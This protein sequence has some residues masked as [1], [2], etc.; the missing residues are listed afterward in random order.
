M[1]CVSCEVRT[2]FVYITELWILPT[3]CIC[4]LRMVHTINNECSPNSINLSVLVAEMYCVSCEVR[5]EFLCIVYK[6]FKMTCESTWIALRKSVNTPIQ[7]SDRVC[8]RKSQLERRV[9]M[10]G[11]VCNNMFVY[12]N[13]SHSCYLRRVDTAGS[14]RVATPIHMRTRAVWHMNDACN[15][16]TVEVW[17]I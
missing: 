5:T 3:Q 13:Y 4:V 1:Y 15:Y 10:K 6:K 7:L 16:T 12:I 2:E 11:R 17:V 8:I 14:M 9:R